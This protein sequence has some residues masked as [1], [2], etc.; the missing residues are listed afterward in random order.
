MY[1][2]ASSRV[3]LSRHEATEEFPCQ[4]G[5]RQGC[6]LSP[7][8]FSLFLSGLEAELQSND[9]GV[10]LNNS[11]ITTLMFVDDIILLSASVNGLREHLDTLQSFCQVWR[12]GLNT[13]K[14][15]ICIFGRSADKYP[16]LWK[17]VALER[18]NAYK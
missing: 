15:K 14:T 18:V 1:F 17:G 3:R 4:K 6:N 12:M 7:L 2:K 16:F 5:V 13:K 8:L 10:H 9:A 11:Y